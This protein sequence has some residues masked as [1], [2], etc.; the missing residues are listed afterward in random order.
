L[1]RIS[2]QSD[3]FLLIAMVKF[4]VELLNSNADGMHMAST[5]ESGNELSVDNDSENIILSKEDHERH[6]HDIS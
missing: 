5:Q 1:W 6:S 2:F 3:F 4:N